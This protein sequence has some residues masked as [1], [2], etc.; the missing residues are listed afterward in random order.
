MV[1]VVLIFHKSGRSHAILSD[2][3]VIPIWFVGE[4]LIICLTLILKVLLYLI[5]SFL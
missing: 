4:G 1:V 5:I 3:I 2:H